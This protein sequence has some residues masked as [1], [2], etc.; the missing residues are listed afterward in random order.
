MKG[1]VKLDGWHEG[2]LG[3][4]RDDGK[5]CATICKRQEGVETMPSTASGLKSAWVY[6][7]VQLN[8]IDDS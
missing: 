1:W 7:N 2:G 4:Q 5:G 6:R 3:Q 8:F